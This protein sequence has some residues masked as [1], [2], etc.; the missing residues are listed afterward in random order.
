MGEFAFGSPLKHNDLTARITEHYN[1]L[2]WTFLDVT[3]MMNSCSVSPIGSTVMQETEVNS[4]SNH[5]IT[6]NI[7]QGNGESTEQGIVS[8][9]WYFVEIYSYATSIDLQCQKCKIWSIGFSDTSM[10]KAMGE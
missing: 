10:K 4:T 7:S 2:N 5:Q 9:Q 8:V 3:A 6:S 1:A